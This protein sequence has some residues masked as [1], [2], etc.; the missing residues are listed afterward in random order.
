MGPSWDALGIISD[1]GL[2]MK[3]GVILV[4]AKSHIPEIYGTGCQASPASL[5]RIQ[6]AISDARS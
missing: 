3:P 4:E 5:V 6:A 2:K 1:P